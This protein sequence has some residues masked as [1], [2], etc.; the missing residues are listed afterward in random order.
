[1]TMT[2]GRASSRAEVSAKVGGRATAGQPLPYSAVVLRARLNFEPNFGRRN[3]PIVP[4]TIARPYICVCFCQS[5][6][7]PALVRKPLAQ[8]EIQ[9]SSALFGHTIL[10]QTQ[11]SAQLSR[12]KAAAAGWLAELQADDCDRTSSPL[13]SLA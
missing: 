1:M 2:G 4:Q 5:V 12:P 10:G 6:G 8:A 7:R 11:L 13:A 3:W 9:V